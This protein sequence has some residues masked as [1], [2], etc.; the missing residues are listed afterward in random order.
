MSSPT[1]AP[2]VRSLKLRS[3]TPSSSKLG[4]GRPSR[5]SPMRRS[6]EPAYHTNLRRGTGSGR[7]VLQ[8]LKGEYSYRVYRGNAIWASRF[9]IM[10]ALCQGL[11]RSNSD[12]K[13]RS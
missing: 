11:T 1:I 13:N 12:G 6:C 10:E 4:V 8:K 7:A 2:K 3:Q 9:V 5:Q